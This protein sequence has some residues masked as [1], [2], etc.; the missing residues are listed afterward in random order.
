VGVQEADLLVV[1][2]GVAGLVAARRAQQLGCSVTV[3]EKHD[4]GPGLGNGRFSGG[5]FH[6]SKMTP[7]TDPD[8]LYST[9]LAKTDGAARS[10]V[11]RA[12]ADNVNRAFQFLKS[13]GGD[14][15]PLDDEDPERRNALMPQRPA[16][17]GQHWQGTGV[18][19]V[20]TAMWRRF[21][22]GGGTFL[23][24]HRARR[25]LVCD[26]AVVGLVA[27]TADGESERRGSHVLLADGGFQG[28]PELVAR[29]ITAGYKLRGSPNDTGDALQMGLAVGAVAV[30]MDAFYGWPLCEDALRDDRLWP[31]P[32]P[33]ALITGGVLVDDH[34]RRFVDEGL[35]GERV[36]VA[37]AKS[38]T[39]QRCWA[40]CDATVW[41]GVARQGD[42]PINPTLADVGGTVLV[43]ASPEEVAVAAGLPAGGVAR[44]VAEVT[45][46]V[47]GAVPRTGE[48][49]SFAR[50]PFVGVPVVAGITFAMG[51]LLVNGRG[52]VLDD[53]DTPIPGLHAAGG[54][55]G[56]LQGGPRAGYSGGWSEAS[57]FG[58]LVAEDVARAVGKA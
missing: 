50:A 36:A 57:T 15:Q 41:E 54:A 5:W 45:G 40:I 12:W 37:I 4:E 48:V 9:I 44:S 53:T 23:A 22:D 27:E 42:V 30:N 13:E 46:D 6:A 28:N 18:D 19:L 58:L 2:G 34:G 39:P 56:G 49:P 21:V 38:D 17:I 25:L 29:Y 26:G 31:Y 3:L 10:D 33:P 11:A 47:V 7:T 55:M 20:L 1:G 35:T 8:R 52:Q 43:G 51:G 24:A 14:F 16:K 32:G